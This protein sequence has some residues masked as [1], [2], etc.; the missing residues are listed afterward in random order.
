MILDK[1]F[2]K[3]TTNVTNCKDFAIIRNYM[4]ANRQI[5][6]KLMFSCHTI[7]DIKNI[8]IKSNPLLHMIFDYETPNRGD[9]RGKGELLVI[10]LVEDAYLSNKSDI[11][12][13]GELKQVKAYKSSKDAIAFGVENQMMK[14]Q[15]GRNLMRLF[16]E[17]ELKADDEKFKRMFPFW[18]GT[19]N[20]GTWDGDYKLFKFMSMEIPQTEFQ[21]FWKEIPKLKGYIN[22]IY[23]DDINK[24][25]EDVDK[26]NSQF[27]DRDQS[28]VLFVKDNLHTTD[29]E[30]KALLVTQNRIKMVLS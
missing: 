26:F 9:K 3:L 12:V 28:I 30:Y 13:N 25:T 27:N 4:L 15:F 11:E 24:L 21:A 23:V 10:F 8:N 20:R 1:F 16:L 18:F 17:I 19:K 7:E 2:D 14:T 29:A 22:N 6:E 5:A